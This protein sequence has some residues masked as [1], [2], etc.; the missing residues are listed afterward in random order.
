MRLTLPLYAGGFLGPFGGAM[1]VALIPNI[2]DGLDTSLGLVAASITAYMVPFAALQLVSGTVA[3]RIGARRVVRTGYLVFGAAALACALAPEIWSFLA[4]RAVMGAANAFLSPILLAALSEVV[5][6]AVLGRTVGTFAAWQTAGFT[7]APA[8]GG[9]LG[10]VSWR[11]AF[12][13]V[14]VAALVL[15]LPRQ[16]LGS[17]EATGSRGASFAVLRSRWM[18][19]LSA[20]ALLGYLGFTAIGF[21]LVLVAA[22]EFGLSSG[23]R[24]LLVAGYGLGGVFL[25]RFAG[26]V[27][28]RAGRP[29]TALAGAVVCAVGV[30]ALAWAPTVWTLALLWL[31]IGCAGTFVWAGLNT[32]A[33][34]S[35]PRNRA[36]A[37]SLF[38][39]FK[40]AGVAI[41]PLLYVP[42]F[43]RDARAPFLV[44]AAFTLLLAV[45]LA[46]WFSRYREVPA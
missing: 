35:F 44:A 31:A 26:S 45:L 43:E 21:V 22:E 12:A 34:E 10:E 15:A 20:K 11:L 32:M 8:I 39:A 46:P 29:G 40:F 41:G 16:T 4:A 25:G 28:D 1:L 3:E 18:A 7:L 27:V 13:I 33:V 38:S 23:E 36:G 42:I 30:F 37:T 2:A 24:G 14:T 6:P 19:L 17:F 9:A 5:A